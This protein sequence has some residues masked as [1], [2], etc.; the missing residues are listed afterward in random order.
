MTNRAGHQ[1][2]LKLL[3]GQIYAV[4]CEGQVV[5]YDQLFFAIVPEYLSHPDGFQVLV[6]ETPND[7]DA[8]YESRSRAFHYSGGP[9]PLPRVLTHYLNPKLTVELPLPAIPANTAKP[10]PKK[11]AI[12]PKNT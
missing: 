7:A 5:F 1:A 3:Q 12:K 8:L 6:A 2:L 9:M 4:K 10:K 11:R